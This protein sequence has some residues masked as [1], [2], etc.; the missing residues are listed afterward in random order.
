MSRSVVDAIGDDLEIV[1]DQ[2]TSMKSVKLHK[3]SSF[4][5][6][7]SAFY[8]DFGETATNLQTQEVSTNSIYNS[9]CHATVNL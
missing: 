7:I 2:N 8:G 9:N 3:Q 1:Y 4:S 6:M 5:S